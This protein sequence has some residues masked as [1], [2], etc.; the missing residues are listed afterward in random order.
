M[1][2]SFHLPSERS[3]TRVTHI[4]CCPREPRRWFSGTL[5]CILLLI[6]VGRDSLGSGS[7][8]N[9]EG[10]QAG[11][12][13]ME[14]GEPWKDMLEQHGHPARDLVITLCREKTAMSLKEIGERCGGMDYAAVLQAFSRMRKRMGAHGPLQEK[15][16]KL[17][18]SLFVEC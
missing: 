8:H 6:R 9:R 3:N 16:Q 15:Y 2:G 5:N 13:E 4:Q 18:N 12:V 11:L 14:F 17:R 10:A 7:E 1:R